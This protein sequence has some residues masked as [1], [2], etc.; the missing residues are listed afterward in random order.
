MQPHHQYD[1][2]HLYH[3]HE[4]FW[5]IFQVHLSSF[6]NLDDYIYMDTS[7]N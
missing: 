2:M 1:T 5:L 6:Y 7:N 3:L 4:M